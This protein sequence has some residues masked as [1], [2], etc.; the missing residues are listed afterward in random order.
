MEEIEYITKIE[1]AGLL[2]VSTRT[3]D[4]LVKAKKLVKYMRL[5]RTYFSAEE[6]R[7]L[8]TPSAVVH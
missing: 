6:V 8:N 1:V 7:K 4:R 2:R 5:G 3:V